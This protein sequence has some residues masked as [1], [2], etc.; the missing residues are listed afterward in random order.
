MTRI[1]A[2]AS[3]KGGVGKTTTAIN[4]GRALHHFSCDSLV[5]DA[6]LTTPNLSLQL[7]SPIV[8]VTL[9]DSLK[10]KASI[11]D[12]AYMHPSGLRVIPASIAFTEMNSVS[13]D[14]LREVMPDLHGTADVILLDAAAGLGEETLAAIS[15]SHEVLIVTNPES[16]AVADALKTIRLAQKHGKEVLGVVVTRFHGDKYD[17]SLKDIEHILEHRIIGVIPEDGAVRKSHALKYPVVHSHPK[18]PSAKSY[19]NLAATILG[20]QHH[21]PH[22]EIGET[23]LYH[24][25]MKHL[26]L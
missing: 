10:G 26:G 1:I 22:V 3:G 8:P 20:V 11:R 15:S 12:A 21:E 16:S 19:R 25:I 2:I 18:S 24:R 23:S 14:R 5:L 9:H 4:L 13:A 7:G 6:N 17:M